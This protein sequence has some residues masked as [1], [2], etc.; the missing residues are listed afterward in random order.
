M[1]VPSP[2]LWVFMACSRTNAFYVSKNTTIRS[3]FAKP[4]AET[5]LYP[6]V[7]CVKTDVDELQ[8]HV[9]TTTHILSTLDGNWF[10]VCVS[11]SPTSTVELCA[12]F[13]NSSSTHPS[14]PRGT[15]ECLQAGDSHACLDV[16]SL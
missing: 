16:T 3:Y 11:R 9:D 5:L 8:E 7:S 15:V 4:K 10:M 13:A 12:G 6:I 2:P 14:S 1:S